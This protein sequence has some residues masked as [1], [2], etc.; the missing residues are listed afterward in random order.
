MG[1]TLI[2]GIKRRDPS[3]PTP[4]PTDSLIIRDWTN[5]YKSDPMFKDVFEILSCKNA[6][7]M[8]FPLNIR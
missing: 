2:S 7:K 3:T 4:L 5:D 6:I 1:R 8:G